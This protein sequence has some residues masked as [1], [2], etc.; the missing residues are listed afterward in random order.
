MSSHRNQLHEEASEWNSDDE[1]QYLE[2]LEDQR[3]F[4]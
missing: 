2:Y 4:F 1:E 3:Q